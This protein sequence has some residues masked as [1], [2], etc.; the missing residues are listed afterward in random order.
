MTIAS[1]DGKS[2]IDVSTAGGMLAT[3]ADAIKCIP[4]MAGDKR[5]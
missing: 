4:L 1:L 3:F 5:G 2:S